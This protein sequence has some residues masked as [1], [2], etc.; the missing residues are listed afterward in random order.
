[1]VAHIVL[2][3]LQLVQHLLASLLSKH[4]LRGDIWLVDISECRRFY[5]ILLVLHHIGQVLLLASLL[6]LKFSAL[7]H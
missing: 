7:I 4:R 3:Q 1:M 2:H 5:L 6:T